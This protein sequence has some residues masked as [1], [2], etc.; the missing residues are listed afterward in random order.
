MGAHTHTTEPKIC[1]AFHFLKHCEEIYTRTFYF[2]WCSSKNKFRKDSSLLMF[3][4]SPDVFPKWCWHYQGYE[5]L[6]S[7]DPLLS[8][9]VHF[10]LPLGS[11]F[12]LPDER[13]NKWRKISWSLSACVDIL[14]K[15]RFLVHLLLFK[16]CYFSKELKII[17]PEEWQVNRWLMN[18]KWWVLKNVHACL[19]SASSSAMRESFCC[20]TWVASRCFVSCFSTCGKKT[21]IV[22]I[23]NTINYHL[24]PHQQDFRAKALICPK[25]QSLLTS[26]TDTTLHHG[27]K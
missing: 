15:H 3:S 14:I 24:S 9:T 2:L 10:P 4:L 18:I 5:C 21:I 26:D 1:L 6:H 16:I 27:F 19:I 17:K 22:D 11:G 12:F 8:L 20:T 13:Q 23:S 7:R 25:S